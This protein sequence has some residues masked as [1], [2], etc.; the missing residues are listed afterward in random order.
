[1]LRLLVP[2]LLLRLFW[3]SRGNGGYRAQIWHRLGL[4]GPHRAALARERVWVHAVSVGE[5]LAIIP[6]IERLLAERPEARVLITSTT[7]TGAEQVRQKLGDRVDW[8]WVPFDTPGAVKRFFAHWHPTL[9]VL[10]ETEIW[11]NSGHPCGCPR[12][13]HGA[14][15][16]PVVQAV[17]PRVRARRW[18]NPSYAG[19]SFGCC[20]TR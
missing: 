4:Y 9:G 5:T 20:C 10:V 3:R 11:P 12:G 16:C 15:E 19:L 7:P 1:M 6:L 17:S 13:A 2:L 18:I 14:A 8:D